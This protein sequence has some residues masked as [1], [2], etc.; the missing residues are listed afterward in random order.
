MADMCLIEER[1]SCR[2]GVVLFGGAVDRL[3]EMRVRE[4]DGSTQPTEGQPPVVRARGNDAAVNTVQHELHDQ[5]W[6]KC[7]DRHYNAG[8]HSHVCSRIRV[9]MQ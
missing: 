7:F 4:W 3:C 2:C 9:H 5:H 1:C 8:R 6:T